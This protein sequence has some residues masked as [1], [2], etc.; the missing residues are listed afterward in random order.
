MA[1]I[2]PFVKWAGG[3]GKLAQT[4]E[5]HLPLDFNEHCDINY[6]EPFVGGG[7]MMFHML[8]HHKNISRIIIND[9]NEDLMR[10]YKLIK[11]DPYKLIEHLKVLEDEFYALA[12]E[13]AKKDFY[14]IIR[15]AFNN[16]PKGNERA[17]Q[18][19]FLNHTCFNGLYRENKSG[20]FNVPFGRYINPTICNEE[21]I[22]ADHEA[23]SKVEILNDDYHVIANY[24]GKAYRFLQVR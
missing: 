16:S 15:D 13:N 19:M 2:K 22:L 24:I 5:G 6:I 11:D 23:L 9:L 21:L 14:Y 20:H 7:A 3:K 10:C 1:K 8:E 4:L 12:T 17:A 18:F